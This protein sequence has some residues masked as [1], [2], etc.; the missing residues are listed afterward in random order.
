MLIKEI[1]ESFIEK[2]EMIGSFEKTTGNFDKK[3]NLI[4]ASIPT[5]T[6]EFCEIGSYDDIIYFTF[7]IYSDS[8]NKKIIGNLRDFSNFQI[9]GFKNFL[10]NLYPKE[11]F[12]FKEFER[13]L[14]KEEYFQI[15]FDYSVENDVEY[16]YEQYSKIKN[17]I[18]DSE[19]RV[20]NQLKIDL[21]KQQ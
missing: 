6:T 7:V 19:V 11:N 17:L 12:N 20:V 4:E 15:N 1:R 3:G 18:L 14:K 21:T 8:Y 2:G 9:Y 5:V 13:E 16:L 10:E